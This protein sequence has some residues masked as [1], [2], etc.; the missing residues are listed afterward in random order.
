M[1]KKENNKKIITSKKEK[2]SVPGA[3]KEWRQA[4][5][6]TFKALGWIAAMFL[7]SLTVQVMTENRV[8]VVNPNRVSEEAVVFKK[9]REQQAKYEAQLNAESSVEMAALQ[10]EQNKLEAE[11]K[12]MKA[13]EFQKKQEALSEKIMA[14]KRKYAYR[15]RQIV[16]ASQ[17]A[18]ASTEKT[19]NEVIKRVA[20]QEK[21][22]IILSAA[23]VM[24]A[25]DKTNDITKEFVEEMNKTI[26]EVS[27]P[28]PATIS[29]K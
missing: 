3:G 1:L 29:I 28:D 17:M 8:V 16:T 18:A 24:S 4:G 7:V 12:K 15:V 20:K 25:D 2:A 26:S 19:T 9:I 6:R 23:N 21:A 14:F 11:K 27:Y 5:L 13:D 22:G 10:E